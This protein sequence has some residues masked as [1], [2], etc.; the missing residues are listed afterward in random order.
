MQNGMLP[1]ILPRAEVDAL[2][3]DCDEGKRLDVD[4]ASQSITREDGSK[5]TFDIDAFRKN[6]LLNGLDDIGITLQ[7]SDKI[8]SFEQARS[9][10]APWF[11]NAAQV[12]VPL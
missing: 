12:C 2:M 7:K 3:K 11:D 1:I 8:A 9:K 10:V 6:C 5:M 4:L